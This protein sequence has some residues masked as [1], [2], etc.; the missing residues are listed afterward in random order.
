MQSVASQIC[1]IEIAVD[2]P[3]KGSPNARLAKECKLGGAKGV[4]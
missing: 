2:Y 3:E 1:D 4:N